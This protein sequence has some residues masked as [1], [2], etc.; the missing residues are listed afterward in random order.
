MRRSD[1]TGLN[2]TAA[3]VS[4]NSVA[5]AALPLKI[6][7]AS[8]FHDDRREKGSVGVAQFSHH[9]TK[10]SAV[11]RTAERL[12]VSPPFVGDFTLP[13]PPTANLYWRT[14]RTGRTYVSADARN[15]KAAVAAILQGSTPTTES[16]SVR[17]HVYRP[18]KRGD[19]DN[20]LKVLFDALKGFVFVDDDQVTHIEA[21]RHDD[22]HNPRAEVVVAAA[23]R[24][25]TEAAP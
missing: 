12:L 21:W 6:A 14:T 15:Y 25:T 24:G 10:R 19:L 23:F 1:L 9:D 22:K 8:E 3:F 18:R 13:Y 11:G 2:L 16:V 17:V 7:V 20:T 4:S 5:R